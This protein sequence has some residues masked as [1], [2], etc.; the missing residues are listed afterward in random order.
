ACLVF[1]VTTGTTSAKVTH[2]CKNATPRSAAD[3]SALL[4]T[5]SVFATLH[6]TFA[7]RTAL[8]GG[9]RVSSAV[10]FRMMTCNCTRRSRSRVR[11][12]VRYGASGW[13]SELRRSR[14]P[15]ARPT[16]SLDAPG[17]PWLN[18]YERGHSRLHINRYTS[19]LWGSQG[20]STILA[21]QFIA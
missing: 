11:V 2:R 7:P 18:D 17:G 1:S 21:H 13:C 19:A 9:K 10:N 12:S 5:G 14:Y 15:W 6:A 4:T 20:F 8:D 3:T 16:G